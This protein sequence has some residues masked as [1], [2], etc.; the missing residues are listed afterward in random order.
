MNVAG[1]I[2]IG[3]SELAE[4]PEWGIRALPAKIDTGARNSALHVQDIEEFGRNRV[5]F[6]V[7]LHRRKRD[8]HVHVEARVTRRGR[9]RSSSGH[10]D[11]RIFVSTKLRLG[12]LTREVELSLVDREQMIFRMLIGRSA[13]AGAYLIDPSRRSLLKSHVR[14]KVK[15]RTPPRRG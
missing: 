2:L 12:P 4:L 6:Q 14:P 7:V 1:R 10:Y 8:R 9:V 15:K 13:L 3:W 11:T 5:R